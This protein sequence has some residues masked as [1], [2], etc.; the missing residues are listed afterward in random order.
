[1]GVVI[2]LGNNFIQVLDSGSTTATTAG[3][4]TSDKFGRDASP[5]AA[6]TSYLARGASNGVGYRALITWCRT[7]R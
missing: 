4:L 5:F 1:M 6:L 2:A 7:G 3:L